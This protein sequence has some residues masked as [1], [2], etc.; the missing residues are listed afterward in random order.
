M[1]YYEI[2]LQTP[3]VWKLWPLLPLD[4]GETLSKSDYAADDLDTMRRAEVRIGS[5]SE[6]SG[7]MRKLRP[8]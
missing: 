5:K 2:S 6:I 8:V 7:W 3:S 1:G 4:Y